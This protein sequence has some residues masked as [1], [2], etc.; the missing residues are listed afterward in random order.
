[1]ID[2]GVCV[3]RVWSPCVQRLAKQRR[4]LTHANNIMTLIDELAVPV[5]LD[6]AHTDTD[7]IKIEERPH[8]RARSC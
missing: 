7:P 6:E 1:M 4:G 3:K 5:R 8:S 2:L